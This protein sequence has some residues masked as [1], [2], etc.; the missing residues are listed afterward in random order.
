MVVDVVLMV[1]LGIVEAFERDYLR[2]DRPRKHFRLVELIDVRFGHAL[3]FVIRI[4]D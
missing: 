3:L 4:E 2:H 1:L